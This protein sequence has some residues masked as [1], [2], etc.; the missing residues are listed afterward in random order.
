MLPER[1]ELIVMLGGIRSTA[2]VTDDCASWPNQLVTLAVTACDPVASPAHASALKVPENVFVPEGE[3]V[4]EL[5]RVMLEYAP[6]TAIQ[7]PVRSTPDTPTVKLGAVALK[8]CP[9]W[10]ADNVTTG[11]AR[12]KYTRGY[13]SVRPL[14][15]AYGMEATNETPAPEFCPS[16]YNGRLWLTE[17]AGFW[18][19]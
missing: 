3:K 19:Q 16:K 5:P 14:A 4:P 7:A 12:G 11:A 6:S 10:G 18:V 15:M 13:E 2:T 17:A 8:T 1:G 9:C